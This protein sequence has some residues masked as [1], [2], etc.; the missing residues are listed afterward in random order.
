MGEVMCKV[1]SYVQGVSVVASID[2]LVAVSLD[3]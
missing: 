2:S 3:R 1:V